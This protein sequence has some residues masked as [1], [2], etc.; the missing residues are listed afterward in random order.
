M[1]NAFVASS[2]KVV[3]NSV[4]TLLIGLLAY[5]CYRRYQETSSLNSLGLLIVNCIFV[6][7]YIAKRD[8][9]SIAVSPWLWLLGLA[10]S[11]APLLLRPAD[12]T[13]STLATIGNA[14]QLLGIVAIGASLLSLRRSF[15]IVPAN[16][17]VQTDG[18]YSYVRHPL[19]A[20]ELL[21]MFGFVLANLS[22]SNLVL[23][24]IDCALQ[25]ARA[26]AEERFLLADPAYR[27]YLA[28]V[29]YRLIPR[30]V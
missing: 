4:V 2:L 29:R 1:P 20:S 7:L 3:A 17:G 13:P 11:C 12:A 15:G 8:A 9:T 23:W 26:V 14:I 10:G 16:R 27:K 19:Y 18:L 5:S 24:V 28:R 22:V 21:W 30:L 6:V 25:L